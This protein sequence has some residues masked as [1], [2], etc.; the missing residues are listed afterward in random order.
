MSENANP[1]G[2]HSAS[3]STQAAKKRRVRS[4]FLGD[5]GGL[6]ESCIDNVAVKRRRARGKKLDSK[7]VVE[8]ST[9]SQA[10]DQRELLEE[11]GV[12]LLSDNS[13]SCDSHLPAAVPSFKVLKVMNTNSQSNSSLG[14]GFSPHLSPLQRPKP[15]H[16]NNTI[17]NIRLDAGS[18]SFLSGGSSNVSLS[19]TSGLLGESGIDEDYFSYCYSHSQTRRREAGGGRGGP[20]LF[21]RMSD[22]II[23]SIFRWLP[24]SSLAKCARVCKTWH[25][26]SSD[27]SLW[28]RLD[29]GVSSVPAGVA[30]QILARGC[31]VLRLA[32][33]SVDQPIFSSHV[34]NLPTFPRGEVSM[35]KLQFLDLSSAAVMVTCLELLLSHCNLLRNLSL[36]MCTV[37]DIVCAAI[38]G[39]RDLSVLHMGMANGIT[40]TGLS[41]ILRGCR[42]LT[43]LNLGWTNL[44]SESLTAIS[45]SLSPALRRLNLSGNRETLLDS[46]VEHILV[47]CPNLRE[48]D[49]SDSSKVSSA[50]ICSVVENLHHIESLS[51]SRCYSITP[52][53]YL[54]LSSSPTL[55]YLNVFGL[56]R[57]GALEELKERLQGIEINKFLFTSVA[58]PTVGIK[59]TS[60]WNLRVRD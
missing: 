4:G 13:N 51:T 45:R 3:K 19:D 23:L 6:E 31:S 60:I 22:E 53:S 36:E 27:E 15:R 8:A 29:L 1:G 17:S 14:K 38:A 24:K 16:P 9:S 46:H 32:R 50:I 52:S 18:S 34:T 26:L 44:T 56:L 55:L 28:R 35:S 21:N 47:N 59:R 20:D 57:E 37:S 43:E 11:M 41:K 39:N 5:S 12:N 33:A 58:R 40:S 7:V 48:L 49:I 30:G 25:R 10:Q 2:S 54:M 42:Q